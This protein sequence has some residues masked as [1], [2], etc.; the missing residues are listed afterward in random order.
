MKNFFKMVFFNFVFFGIYLLSYIFPQYSWI[1]RYFYYILYPIIIFFMI[2]F[3]GFP[4]IVFE[5]DKELYV[6]LAEKKNIVHRIFRVLFDII[7]LSFFVYS[8]WRAVFVLY[9]ITKILHC[10][11]K[12][13]VA[14]CGENNV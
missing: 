5:N 14:K 3:I 8:E 12:K 6:L 4:S 11:V 9:V 1:V 2:I 10:L 7:H 13:A